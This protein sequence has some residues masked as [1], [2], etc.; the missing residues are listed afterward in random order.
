MHLQG[1]LERVAAF[2]RDVLGLSELKRHRKP[3][4]T[5]RKRS[6]S[7]LGQWAGEGQ[8]RQVAIQVDFLSPFWRER[9]RSENEL[10]CQCLAR[11]QL[12]TLLADAA[13]PLGSID[14]QHDS[15]RVTERELPAGGL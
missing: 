9:R 3:D 15:V 8:S 7:S 10:D 2:Y 13:D 1:F 4:G 11:D 6:A 14:C 12:G 5:L